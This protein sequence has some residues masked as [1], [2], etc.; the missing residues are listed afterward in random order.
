MNQAMIQL[1][2]EVGAIAGFVVR[3][4]FAVT[5]ALLCAFVA[6][7]ISKR[8][9]AAVRH[10]VWSLGVLVSLL[11]PAMLLVA[12]ERRFGLIGSNRNAIEPGMS[13]RLESSDVSIRENAVPG[14]TAPDTNSLGELKIGNASVVAVP[15]TSGFPVAMPRSRASAWA[16]WL[17]IGWSIPA[18][19]LM[20]RLIRGA[21]ASRTIVR[22]ATPVDLAGDDPATAPRLPGSISRLLADRTPAVLESPAVQSPLCVGWFGSTILLP[23]NWRGWPRDQ[24]QA[25]LIHELA[26]VAR[27]DVLW[28]AIAR[29]SCALYWP[30]PLVWFAARRMR[31]ERELAC[32]DWVLRGGESPT[33]YAR[34]LLDLACELKA[35]RMNERLGVAMAGRNGLQTRVR[36]ALDPARRR[37]P[38][39]K[40]LS[41]LLTVHAALLLILAG[42]LSP[43]RAVETRADKPTVKT[44]P[45]ASTP[46]TQ[47]S[48]LGDKM[49]RF[50][51][52]RVVDES[53]HGVSGARITVPPT[54]P[55][56]ATHTA[57]ADAD[58]R[59][60]VMIEPRKQVRLV[61]RAE[62][63][64][65]KMQTRLVLPPRRSFT[66]ADFEN[67]QLTLKPAAEYAITVTDAANRPV[68]GAKIV[69]GLDQLQ[70]TSDADGKAT[71]RL[72][73]GQSPIFILARKD[74]TGFDYVL[75]SWNNLRRADPSGFAAD[76]VGPIHFVLNGMRTIA[77]KVVDDK[78]RPLAGVKVNPRMLTKAGKG[79]LFLTAS[80]PDQAVETD[81]AGIARISVP[82]DVDKPVVF[83]TEL[84]GYSQSVRASWNPKSPTEE[85]KVILLQRP[86]F[87]LSV[88]DVDGKP[89]GGAQVMLVDDHGSQMYGIFSNGSV[90]QDGTAD[91]MLLP[92]TYYMFAAMKGQTASDPVMRVARAGGPPIRVELKLKPAVRVHG[93]LT[94]G[95]QALPAANSNIHIQFDDGDSYR[96]LPLDQRLPADAVGPREIH[97]AVMFNRPT[98]KQG[99]F[100][101]FLA[102]GTYHFVDP[103]EMS[104]GPL[105]G[106]SFVVSGDRAD[107]KIDWHYKV[108]PRVTVP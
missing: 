59:F 9:S 50:V 6:S 27:R 70:T 72:P 7:A 54:S 73:A 78:T 4:A 61:L 30:H 16:M 39:S 81:S 97:P 87:H 32:D 28:Q 83:T 93:Q 86:T 53:G 62:S 66:Q 69:A 19:F 31:I 96:K 26:H 38:L 52:G 13:A 58:G 18:V 68:A 55:Y 48:A 71:L 100:E 10:K 94:A 67:I 5:A 102:P 41:L 8:Q 106:Q 77:V 98:D 65:G 84:G 64:D 74:D 37:M 105:K 23:A 17:C 3:L 99:N 33:R 75:F 20:V 36:A 90:G 29:L 63:R 101:V 104:A 46:S 88:I 12:P 89:A 60:V 24:L 34:W 103:A 43:L 95:N 107:V 82:A 91:G 45:D 57:S 21:I 49:L 44:S 51:A 15:R 14:T 22:R 35:A 80:T 42:S 2:M 56:P 11:I 40:R 108:S 76:Y 47:P 92:D 85:V 25:V 79:E 1:P